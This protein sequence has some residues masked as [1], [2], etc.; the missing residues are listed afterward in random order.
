[1]VNIMEVRV[2]FELTV[3]LV[4]NQLPLTTRPSHHNLAESNGFEPLRLF[5]NDSL[6]NC[7][8]NHSPN[9]PCLAEAVRFELTE[10]FCSLVFKT[11]AINLTR[12]HFQYH[13][14]T[15]SR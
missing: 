9:S 15:H 14:E 10:H 8:F 7:W 12:P 13:I 3:V 6:A 4:C 5:R 1:M 2:R 11:S